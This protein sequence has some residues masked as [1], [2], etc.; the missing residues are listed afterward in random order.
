MTGAPWPA[1]EAR[2]LKWPKSPGEGKAVRK[3]SCKIFASLMGTAVAIAF[4][5][6]TSAAAWTRSV[7]TDR[8]TDQKN[9]FYSTKAQAPIHQFGR[10]VTVVLFLT[11]KS[12]GTHSSQL[13]FS[14]RISVG[15]PRL[16]FRFDKNEIFGPYKPNISDRGDA[17]FPYVDEFMSQMPQSSKLR[18]EI[19]LPWAGDVL[20][21]FKT[22][23]ADKALA[24]IPCPRIR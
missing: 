23:G 9:I 15:E 11:C 19:A 22:A 20:L 3:S 18:I 4:A 12:D 14:E 16:R 2:L 10:D 17:I 1:I 24:G 8:L 13:G 21:E 5:G 6:L 7:E